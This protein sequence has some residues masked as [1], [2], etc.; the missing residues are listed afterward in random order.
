MP[1]IRTLPDDVATS[2]PDETNLLQALLRASVPIAHACG[3]AALCSTCRVRLIDGHEACS[4]RT[5]AETAM[6]ERLQLP[7]DIR[8]ACQTTVRGDVRI[9]RLV[10]D[11]EDEAIASQLGS[12]GGPVGHEAELAVLFADVAGYTTLADALP[13]YDIVHVLNRFFDGAE[14]AINAAGGRV[15]N[16]MGDAVMALFGPD[17]EPPPALSAVRAGLGIQRAAASLDTYVKEL[18][19]RN[20]SVRVGVHFGRVVVGA[21]GGAG[22]RRET[23]IGD[24]VNVASRV[25]SA[26]K[27]S[28]TK[29]LVSDE[30]RGRVADHVVFGGTFDLPLRGKQGRFLVHEVIGLA[31][32]P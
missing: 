8:L 25:E 11:S 7:D 22:T 27:E 28:G 4:P 5:P 23:A 15:N 26:N 3:G 17:A 13:A 16:Y 9:H 21:L 32:E 12:A 14:R 18:Y 10:L 24:A 29:M 31:T 20:F 2:F 1:E 19:G 6:A 30:V